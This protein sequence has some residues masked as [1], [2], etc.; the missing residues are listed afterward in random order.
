MD[1]VAVIIP[2]YNRPDI[3]EE[4]I[5][6]LY[7][8]LKNAELHF[9]IG[10][11]H[12]AEID[13]EPYQG[14]KNLKIFNDPTGSLGANLNRLI[15]EAKKDGHDFLFQ[16]DDD[17]Y[18]KGF[19]NLSTHIDT[20]KREKEIGWIRLMGVAAHRYEAFLEENYWII[21]WNSPELYI[22]SN[23]PHLK[24]MRFHDVNGIYPEG[25]KL[26]ET[27]EAFCHQCKDKASNR[28]QVAIPLTYDDNLWDHVG[29]SW[30]EEG[31]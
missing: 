12:S 22:T 3:L 27:E 5:Y 25:K 8:R 11:D 2:T 31:F 23:R 9:Y 6:R 29:D 24:T 15:L 21:K 13:P 30:Q 19:L 10:N 17:H 26:G 20:L 28:Q 1:K 16:L 14:Y 18:L 4:C 7:A